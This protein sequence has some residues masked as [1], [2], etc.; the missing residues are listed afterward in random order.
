MLT[1]FPRLSNINGRTEVA[2]VNTLE[3][4]FLKWNQE[5]AGDT[6]P[7]TYVAYLHI[8]DNLI[9]IECLK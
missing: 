2:G 1:A 8:Y 6:P 4:S 5:M 7:D 3:V 9:T